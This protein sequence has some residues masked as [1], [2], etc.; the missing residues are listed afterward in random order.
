MSV[1]SSRPTIVSL[2]RAIIIGRFNRLKTSGYTWLGRRQEIGTFGI[3]S[4]VRQR[5]AEEFV[6]KEEDAVGVDS[7]ELFSVHVMSAS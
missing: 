2:E 7:A 4:P 3:K 6:N 1:C 5:S